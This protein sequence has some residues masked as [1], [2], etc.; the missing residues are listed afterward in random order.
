MFRALDETTHRHDPLVHIV[1]QKVPREVTG[2]ALA[3]PNQ[4]KK[5]STKRKLDE[6]CPTF[7]LKTT[8]EKHQLHEKCVYKL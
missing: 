5:S 2:S 6:A 3:E 8:L 4:A 7:N 1:V